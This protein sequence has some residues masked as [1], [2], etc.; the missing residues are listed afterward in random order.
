[1]VNVWHNETSLSGYDVIFLPGGSSYG[2]YLRCGA[3]AAHSAI[4]PAVKKAA[5]EGKL[6][7]GVGNGFQVLTEIG[8]LPGGF[9]RNRSIKFS[10][11]YTNLI[12]ED[13]NTP[14]TNLFEIGESIKIPVAHTEGNYHFEETDKSRIIF[15]YESDG[16]IAG[17]INE[18][19]N[20]LG[21]MPYPERAVDKILGSTDGLRLFESILKNHQSKNCSARQGAA[22]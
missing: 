5:D 7:L 4:I 2:D 8:L 19:G 9:L 1:M 3:L 13:N 10:C 21:M 17:I 16:G 18:N 6:I 15:S 11:R 22:N 14:F 12:V 20:V